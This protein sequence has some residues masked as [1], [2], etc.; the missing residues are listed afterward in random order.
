[1]GFF[2]KELVPKR[3]LFFGKERRT[4]MLIG[5]V[6]E[7]ADWKINLGRRVSNRVFKYALRLERMARRILPPWWIHQKPIDVPPASSGE[8]MLWTEDFALR[9]PNV[10]SEKVSIVAHGSSEWHNWICNAVQPMPQRVYRWMFSERDVFIPAILLHSGPHFRFSL[11]VSLQVCRHGTGLEFNGAH[12]Y[13]LFISSETS[14]DIVKGFRVGDYTQ[15]KKIL[16]SI[17]QSVY[18]YIAGGMKF[19]LD[20]VDLDHVFTTRRASRWVCIY[21]PHADSDGV[22]HEVLLEPTPQGVNIYQYGLVSLGD[23]LEHVDPQCL[24]E[25]HHTSFVCSL[26]TME[27]SFI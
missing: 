8:V 24:A 22:V 4:E 18:P 13:R 15:D 5:V 2:C 12:V 1:M 14:P 25:N 23:L 21:W 17:R 11:K 3:N 19:I 16:S 6:K 20:L 7:A 9:V 27:R 26:E 10:P